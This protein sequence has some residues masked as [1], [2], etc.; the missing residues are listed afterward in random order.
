MLCLLEHPDAVAQ[1]RAAPAMLTAAIEEVLRYRSPVQ[2]V[3]R[4]T[5]REVAVDG[6]SIPPGKMVLPMIGAANRDPRQFVEPDR[7]EIARNPNPH[8]AFGHGI[9]FCIG[10]ALSRLESRIALGDVLARLDGL[11]RASNDPWEPRKALHVHG[12]AK[13]P[14]RF[15]P[16]RHDA[17]SNASS[18]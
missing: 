17:A 5:R 4:F 14:V 15:Q 13:L 2:W 11:Q 12:P 18:M 3:F 7:F 1:L 10:A 9:H 16:A 6:R 8:I